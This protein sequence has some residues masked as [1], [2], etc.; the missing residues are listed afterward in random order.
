MSI[1]GKSRPASSEYRAQFDKVFPP[2]PY[3]QDASSAREVP[4]EHSSASPNG[5]GDGAGL[6]ANRTVWL[7]DSNCDHVVTERYNGI[8]RCRLCGDVVRWAA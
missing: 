3:L 8:T 7:V 2:R 5:N 4:A 6:P 1:D